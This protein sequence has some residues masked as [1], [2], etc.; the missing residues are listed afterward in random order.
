[1]TE[2][3]AS[4]L[5]SLIFPLPSFSSGACSSMAEQRPH[6]PVC[7]LEE[8]LSVNVVKFGEAQ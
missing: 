4:N 3:R 2:E 1:M 5:S 7:P 8:I 6:T